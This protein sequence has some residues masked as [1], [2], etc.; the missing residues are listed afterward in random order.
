MG[1]QDVKDQAARDIEHGV[2][3]L[4]SLVESNVGRADR[5]AQAG[6]DLAQQV[7]SFVQDPE[8]VGTDALE[9]AYGKFMSLHSGN[10]GP[11][12]VGVT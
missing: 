1:V 3:M 4:T 12:W 9:A 2:S 8:G 7:C 6:F 5:A 11:E 10:F